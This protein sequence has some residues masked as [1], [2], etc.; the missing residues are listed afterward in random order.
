ML[1]ANPSG[2]HQRR[3]DRGGTLALVSTDLCFPRNL[4]SWLTCPDTRVGSLPEKFHWDVRAITPEWITR[5]IVL[6]AT[7]I[8]IALGL[9]RACSETA[10]HLRQSIDCASCDGTVATS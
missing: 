3:V 10:T 2:T 5:S 1:Q 6:V 4:D 8:I 7:T 9:V